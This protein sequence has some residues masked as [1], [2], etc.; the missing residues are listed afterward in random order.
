[1]VRPKAETSLHSPSQR[2][3]TLPHHP[4]MSP[5]HITLPRHP[6]DIIMLTS[7]AVLGPTHLHHADVN[8]TS[9]QKRREGENRD[10]GCPDPISEAVFDARLAL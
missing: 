4:T 5:Y 1:V 9:P 6:A 10:F 7:S 3:V 2:D 8:M